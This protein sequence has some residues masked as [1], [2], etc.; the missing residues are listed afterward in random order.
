MSHPACII[1]THARIT[2][3]HPFSSLQAQAPWEAVGD[4]ETGGTSSD[5]EIRLKSLFASHPDDVLRILQRQGVNK[6][7]EFSEKSSIAFPAFAGASI[8][9]LGSERRDIDY[10]SVWREELRRL[11]GVAGE[12][13]TGWAGNVLV[14][15]FVVN[16]AEASD[17]DKD[18]LIQ[19]LLRRWQ[20]GGCSLAVFGLPAVQA[21]ITYKWQ[22]FA[23]RLLLWQL[24]FFLVWCAAFYTFTATFQD[25]DVSLSIFQLLQTPRGWITV[26]CDVVSVVAMAPFLV[27]EFGTLSAY[28]FLG[29][30]NVWNILDVATY[31]T[32]FSV[33]F[34][35][36]SRYGLNTDIL[37]I[38]LALQCIFL[39]FR[40]Q[41]YSRVF[42][43]TRF[44][45]IEAIRDVIYE[46]RQF[47]AFLLLIFFAFA[48]AFN[49][50]FR[51]DQ[52]VSNFDTLAHSFVKVYS[53]QS[54]L[55]YNEMLKSHVPV[56][57]TILNISY[58]FIMGM[59]LVN[60]LVGLM[61]NALNRVTEHEALKMLLHKAQIIDELEATLPRW[62]ED[63]YEKV[64]YP[65]HIHV[66]RIDPDRV[67]RVDLS[68]LWSS[69]G[70][71]GN[72]GGGDGD[73]KKKDSAVLGNNSIEAKL[74]LILRALQAQ[75]VVVGGGGQQSGPATPA[76]LSSIK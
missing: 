15:A 3:S 41:Y 70:E 69:S 65:H 23:R 20:S 57:A 8:L 34:M 24:G 25:E 13:S 60:L 2:P 47:F 32:Q 49:I 4:V 44:S 26:A 58:A 38:L 5:I 16:V 28:G 76:P 6:V 51:K 63:K 71:N 17:P 1:I 62:L 66:L 22:A 46:I 68:G 18:G 14:E 54:G 73:E 42:K 43:S 30:L 7:G 35:H 40:L 11:A 67:E 56:A 29:W 10:Q 45:F 55:D 33:V 21:T 74:D 9:T 12:D 19:P 64:W 36:L 72:G 75:G 61:A 39:L 31:T 59:V 37:S 53:S 48:A 27:L 52:A 50:L